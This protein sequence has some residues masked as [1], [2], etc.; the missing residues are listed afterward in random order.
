MVLIVK[1]QD[2]FFM[3]INSY[4]SHAANVILKAINLDW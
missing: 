2:E 1:Y 3:Y 4:I